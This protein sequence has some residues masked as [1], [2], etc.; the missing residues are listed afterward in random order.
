[1]KT[2]LRILAALGLLGSLAHGQGT[3]PSTPT[4][5]TVAPDLEWTS[6]LP[7]TLYNTNTIVIAGTATDPTSTGGTGTGGTGGTTV[8]ASGVVKVQYRVKGGRWKDAQMVNSGANSSDFFGVIKL[9][10]G[11]TA[12]LSLRC[13][14]R[15][16]NESITYTML[17]KRSRVTRATQTNP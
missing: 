4:V 14:D 13:F 11:K 10:A 6:P 15:T 16:G 17:I 7:G 3:P 8:V 5:D 1:M 2:I 12:R 9:K